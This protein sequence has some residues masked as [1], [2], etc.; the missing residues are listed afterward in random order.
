MKCRNLVIF[1]AAAA[2]HL[3]ACKTPPEKPIST[4]V[5][6]MARGSVRCPL[7][8]R[9][10]AKGE[11][12]LSVF[13]AGEFN[14]WQNG[15]L[16]LEDPDG[17]LVY[18][19]TFD[20]PNVQP[21]RYGYKY[22]V[23]RGGDPQWILDP[24][25]TRRKVSGNEVN[26]LFVLDDCRLPSLSLS[27]VRYDAPSDTGT[28]VAALTS[29]DP[30]QI[31]ESSVQARTSTGEP[32]PATL[33]G[34]RKSITVSVKGRSG[35]KVGVT[36]HVEN[37]TGAAAPLYVP[38]WT[39]DEQFRFEDSTLYFAFTDRF[40]NG[41]FGNDAP[42]SCLPQASP[43]N[44]LGGDFA[45]ITQKIE[46]GYF[47][48]LG[49]DA[50]W[51][52]SP[53]ENPSGCYQ[54]GQGRKYTAY[55][56]YF[57]TSLDKTDPH[58]GSDVELRALVDA[59]HARGIRVLVDF[60]ANHLHEESPLVAVHRDWFNSLYLCGWERPVTCW[61][62][63]YLPDINYDVDGADQ[64]MVGSALDWIKRFDLDGFRVDAAKHIGHPFV[65][66]LRA[67][68]AAQIEHRA[69][70]DQASKAYDF[71]MVGETFT[72]GWTPEDNSQVEMIKE[73]ISPEEL[74][75][76]FDFP[77]WYEILWAFG[78][79][80]VPTDQIKTFLKAHEDAY[81][82]GAVMS[83][84]IDNHDVPRFISHADNKVTGSAAMS[85]TSSDEAKQKGWDER[86][87]PAQPTRLEPYRLA[88]LAY[89]VSVSL[90]PIPLV[91]YGD[92]IGLPGAGD[93]D[94]RRMMLWDGYNDGQRELLAR[95]QSFN[96]LRRAHPALRAKTL[97]M[98]GLTGDAAA[99]NGETLA[100]FKLAPTEEI[101]VLIDR[102]IDGGTDLLPV[103]LPER[104]KLGDQ[105]RDLET[106]EHFTV[107]HAG[108]VSV[109]MNRPG[110]R[111]LLRVKP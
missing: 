108:E 71:Y 62:E 77:L 7:H 93:P 97:E 85:D 31:L 9:F 96:T 20:L 68:I 5:P 106:S 84:F 80:N 23:S 2:L 111:F 55:H 35:T 37:D 82:D 75:G 110:V 107:T 60:V 8:F 21:G 70:P 90:Q 87:R 42:S 43:A 6:V 14:D 18:E 10:D 100:Y 78:K 19:G 49:I 67:E 86:L 103:W 52:S 89:A 46:E 64:A 4:E 28:I 12:Y 54:G 47:S 61:F 17:D 91:Y 51:I 53:N 63:S 83:S 40:N 26:S 38:L 15:K 88:Q 72:G 101:L 95:Y 13:V 66:N 24:T 94:N 73:W 27:S 32:L 50:V 1:L 11:Q 25:N 56:A 48:A 99:V 33:S 105:L 3:A 79:Q 22:V 69:S 109:R 58:F 45:G 98:S 34:D 39:R 104:Y 65:H 102:R 59:A 92:E 44:W 74:T 36:L 81:G 41:N 57:P 16:K 30:S 29:L 76:Q